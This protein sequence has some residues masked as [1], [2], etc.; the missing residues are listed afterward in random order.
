VSVFP[1]RLPF[2]VQKI[3]LYIDSPAIPGWN[4][5]DAVGVTDMSGEEHWAVTVDA[6]S[7][8]AE[9][10]ITPA[11][12]K[13]DWGPEQATGEPDTLEP[14]DRVTAWASQSEDGAAE[15]LVCDYAD[16]AMPAEIVVH[17][18]FNPGAVNK[19]TALDENG[20]ETVL[21]EGLDPTPRDQP[22]GVS[23]FPVEPTVPIK[24]LKIY[25]DSMAVRGWNEIDAVGLRDL[26]GKTQWAATVEASTT[27]A[28][29]RQP[30]L[31]PVDFNSPIV[32]EA[33]PA[34]PEVQPESD[35]LEQLQRS[36]DEL[37][38][39][40]EQLQQ[41]RAEFEALKPS[42]DEPSEQ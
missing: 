17:E 6:S 24:K 13:R 35:R 12:V 8:Y 28:Q 21:W 16:A 32:P 3:K 1:V 37:K 27:Y 36:I 39:Q 40:V 26:D 41:L 33:Q 18:T 15:W 5:I 42:R 10:E 7:T 38:A 34:E 9:Q 23:V 14:G 19:L 11:S 22:R 29:Q 31:V 25:I 2:P 4:E 20:N 30:V